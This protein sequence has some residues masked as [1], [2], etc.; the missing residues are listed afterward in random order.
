M[1]VPKL[2]AAL[3]VI[4]KLTGVLFPAELEAVKPKLHVCIAV[5]VPDIIPLLDPKDKPAQIVPDVIDQLVGELVAESCSVYAEF[6]VPEGRGEVVVMFGGVP[7]D[8][9]VIPQETVLVLLAEST[10]CPLK[11]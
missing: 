9:I 4:L 11:L 10:T 3:V 6:T 1:T 8:A 7:A 2:E 5:G